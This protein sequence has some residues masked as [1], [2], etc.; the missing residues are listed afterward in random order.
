MGS[1]TFMRR[2]RA[3]TGTDFSGE[4]CGQGVSMPWQE[5]RGERDT[6][7]ARQ[8]L[9]RDGLSCDDFVDAVLGKGDVDESEKSVAAELES[10]LASFVN[11]LTKSTAA[12]E[13]ELRTAEEERD[14][15]EHERN[16]QAERADAAEA[17]LLVANAAAAAAAA[18]AAAAK[19]AASKQG[20]ATQREAVK[21]SKKGKAKARHSRDAVRKLVN[22]DGAGGAATMAGGSKKVLE[23]VR[24]IEAAI[25]DGSL[26]NAANAAL[27]IKTLL[28]RKLVQS[29]SDQVH[30]A[31]SLGV[32]AGIVDRLRATLQSL[33]L[34]RRFRHERLAYEALLI[35]IAPEKKS[36]IAKF[37]NRLNVRWQTMAKHQDMRRMLDTAEA[38]AVWY[39]DTVKYEA[40]DFKSKNGGADHQNYLEFFKRSDITNTNPGVNTLVTLHSGG[41]MWHKK[42]NCTEKCQSHVRHELQVMFLLV[43]CFVVCPS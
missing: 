13:D 3:S 41:N 19:V 12:R 35:A 5:R 8:I 22:A 31:L 40:R 7:C 4:F 26:G 38:S 16:E 43:S 9:A 28:E 20:S 32:D 2:E 11:Q 25:A 6:A 39:H 17:R 21:R 10:A 29:L 33:K 42:G 37:A 24:V 34:K 14:E 1:T 27:L 30:D 18:E 15:M 23:A 36:D